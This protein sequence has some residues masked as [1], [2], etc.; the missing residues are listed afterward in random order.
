[1]ERC[2]QEKM[3]GRSDEEGGEEGE[4]RE[5]EVGMVEWE[6]GRR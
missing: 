1:M 4:W 6:Y 2:V 5:E 3:L